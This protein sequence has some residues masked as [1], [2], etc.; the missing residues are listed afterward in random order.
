MYLHHFL[1]A[2][3]AMF[4]SELFQF[5]QIPPGL[6]AYYHLHWQKMQGDNLSP[7]ALGVLQTLVQQ[8]QPISAEAVAKIINED[9]YDVEEVL[10]SWYE[11]LQPQR[12]SRETLYSVYHSSFRNWLARQISNKPG[13]KFPAF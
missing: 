7:M 6:E 12:V 2:I 11:F 13:N 1:N 5:D 10:E 8:L 4:D 3:A 9:A